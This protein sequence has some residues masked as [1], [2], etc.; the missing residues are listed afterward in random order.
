VTL[1]RSA[2]K[3]DLEPPTW[4]LALKLGAAAVLVL[5][6]VRVLPF[7]RWLRFSRTAGLFTEEEMAFVPKLFLLSIAAAASIIAPIAALPAYTQE[8]NP[9]GYGSNQ[10]FLAIP[11]LA[12]AAFLVKQLQL[13]WPVRW[14]ER[15]WTGV[16]RVASYSA[17][18]VLS[19]LLG[20]RLYDLVK[21]QYEIVA[22]Q[23]AGN[24]YTELEDLRRFSGE[25]FVTN[26]N[27][28]PV[29]FFVQSAG[30]AVCG[31]RGVSD[32]GA[33]NVNEC[34]I[35][36]MRQHDLYRSMRPRYFFFFSCGALFPG[37]ADVLPDGVLL[38]QQR[39]NLNA[40]DQMRARLDTHYPCVF[41]NGLFHV[42]DLHRYRAI[43]D[44]E[45]CEPSPD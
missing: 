3:H 11:Q 34:K 37:F 45:A 30:Y 39:G 21:G 22:S 6:L 12:L 38:G 24:P 19:F 27:S 41:Q 25:L 14:S 40:V 7:A 4:E 1:V 9:Q 36:F 5:V 32:D 10:F 23:F 42:Y 33:I 43:Q 29:G 28:P 13:M 18:V 31:A 20:A 2:I 16:A 17:A 15:S 26:I 44:Y 8:C 35:A